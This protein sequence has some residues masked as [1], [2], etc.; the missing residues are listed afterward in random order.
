MTVNVATV[1]TIEELKG[2]S[3]F[4]AAEMRVRRALDESIGSIY[5]ASI[6]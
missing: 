4:D 2:L 5:A 1:I 6:K 3:S